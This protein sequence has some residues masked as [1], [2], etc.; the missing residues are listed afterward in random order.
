MRDLQA[1]AIQNDSADW[2]YWG[3]QPTKYTGYTN[4]SNRLIPVYTFGI[5]LDATCA[6]NTASIAPSAPK[7]I[8][9]SVAGRHT[10]SAC[11]IL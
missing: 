4:H 3:P 10:E 2:G 1:A 7:A 9:R 6:A 5:D 11:R 8:V